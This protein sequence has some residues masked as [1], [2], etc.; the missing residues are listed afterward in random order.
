[1]GAFIPECREKQLPSMGSF[2]P[3]EKKITDPPKTALKKVILLAGPTACGKSALALLL[4]ELLGGEIISV[5]SMQVYRGMDIG[6]A[7]VSQEQLNQVEHHLINIRD[8]Q[9]NFNV[10]D[11][12]YEATQC[13]E[14]ILARGRVPILCGGTGFYFRSFIYGP[15]SGPPSVPSVRTNLELEM[16]VRGAAALFELLRDFDPEYASSITINDKH[17][18]IRA[19]EIIMLTGEKVSALKWQREKPLDNYAFHSWFVYRPREQLYPMIDGRCEQ[20]LELGLMDEVAELDKK[21]LQLNASASQAIGYRQCLDY[22]ASAQTDDDYQQFVNRF[23]I[24]SRNYAKRQFTWFKKE[25]LFHWLNVDI[26]DPEIAAEM[27]A[28]E[29]L[30]AH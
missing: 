2:I 26:H 27:I 12:Y 23:K 10:V 15:P 1:M 22:L 6:T 21:G 25:P 11:F 18:I 3:L 4:A 9:E 20:M 24:A 5:D 7:K 17:K 8:I 16:K 28:Q 14:S 29:Y 19:L 13:C 30:S